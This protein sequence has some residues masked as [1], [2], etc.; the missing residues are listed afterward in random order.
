MSTV[1]SSTVAQPEFSCRLLA[2]SVRDCWFARAESARLMEDIPACFLSL[3]FCSLELP[4]A[5]LRLLTCMGPTRSGSRWGLVSGPSQPVLG[6][7]PGLSVWSPGGAGRT[8]RFCRTPVFTELC[9]AVPSPP[10]RN[11][12]GK[13]SRAEGRPLGSAQLFRQVGWGRPKSL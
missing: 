6:L 11:P 12:P 5:L 1:N 7:R 3:S 9:W 2:V 8:P 10:R 13:V 4:L